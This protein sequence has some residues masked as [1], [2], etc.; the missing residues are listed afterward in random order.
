[1]AKR[2][3]KKDQVEEKRDVDSG[4][5]SGQGRPRRDD[6]DVF[7]AQRDFADFGTHGGPNKTNTSADTSEQRSAPGSDEGK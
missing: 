1:M 3:Q 5:T 4:D 6:G 7:P 2:S